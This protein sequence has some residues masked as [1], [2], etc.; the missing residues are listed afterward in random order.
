MVLKKNHLPAGM[1]RRLLFGRWVPHLLLAFGGLLSIGATWYVDL[2]E[3]ARARAAFQVGATETR[4]QLEGRLKASLDVVRVGAALLATNGEV[5]HEDFGAFV[6]ALQLTDRYP[7]IE[8]IGFSQY[9]RR[10]DLRSFVRAIRLDGVSPFRVRPAGGRPEYHPIILF[11]PRAGRGK[12]ALGFDLWT[13]PVARA[14]MERARDTGQP[15]ASGAVVDAWGGED[16]RQPDLVVYVPVYRAKAA[17]RTV[18]QRRRALNGFVFGPVS[19]QEVL[20]QIVKA[21]TPSVALDLYDET[22]AD[23]PTL[24]YRSAGDAA[25]S[26]FNSLESVQFAGRQWRLA[27]RSS[28]APARVVSPTAWRSLWVGLLLSVL[29]FLITRSQVRAWETSAHQESELRA[30]E[31]ALRQSESELQDVVAR[32]RI[33]RT[34][35]E[36]ADRVKDE[37]LATLSHELRTPLNTV[38]GWLTM[39]RTGSMREDQRTHALEVIE[40]NAR[41]QAQLIEDLLDV[42]RI[43]TGKLRLEARPLNLAPAVST[44]LEALRPTAEAKGVTLQ[45]LIDVEATK[46]LGDPS[47]VQQIFW[48]LVSNAIKFTPPGGHVSV[49]LTKDDGHYVE[50]TVRDTGIGIPPAFLPQIFERF[51]QADSST[52]RVHSGVGLGLSI[53]RDLVKLHGGSVE[54]HSDGADR[55]TSFV[56]RFPAA[57]ASETSP[58]MADECQSPVLDGIRVLVVDDDAETRDLLSEALTRV[59]A[60]VTTAESARQAF[61]QLRT[62]G[63]DVLVSDIGMPLEDGLS[64]MRRIR[65][66][67]GRPGK[68]PAIA[69]TAY[70]R[71]EDRAEAIAAGYQ[72]HLAKPVELAK[73]QAGLAALAASDSVRSSQ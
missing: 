48:N 30:S 32:E 24:I 62:E 5:N 18:R 1:R 36:A 6:E 68:I 65:S 4:R 52:T 20:P 3:R 17:L 59:G 67:A 56:V 21:T 42:S 29:V 9:V 54:A 40:R 53:V 51:R 60:Q 25:T 47:R 64:L 44:V 16:G 10:G 12:T 19:L 61:E 27:L 46:I 63:A 38:L 11:E 58:G 31:Q 34:Q 15:S 50:V 26:R 28:E 2:T 8:G 41:L 55:G 22:S 37:F 23:S 14:A 71:P 72:L 66:L 13:D 39:L 69:L 45:P 7:G 43:V 70:A 57:S 33:A 49:E 73:L 35:I